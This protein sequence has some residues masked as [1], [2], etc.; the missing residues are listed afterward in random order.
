MVH[1]AGGPATGP[2]L[3]EVWRVLAAK[4]HFPHEFSTVEGIIQLKLLLME[5][6]HGRYT[7]I[8]RVSYI[9][10]GVGFQP[11]PP[12]A[13]RRRGRR[14][15]GKTAA[16]TTTTTASTTVTTAAATTT[17][18]TTTTTEKTPATGASKVPATATAA[19]RVATVT[20]PTTATKMKKNHQQI[21]T[22]TEIHE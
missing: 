17:T 15:K 8:Y 2:N 7:V 1:T 20:A 5:E 11:P 13:A 18:T 14:K 16:T 9:S 12:P 4:I 21:Y 10:S 3:L 22:H 19:T 6:T